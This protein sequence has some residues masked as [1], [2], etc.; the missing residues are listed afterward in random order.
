MQKKSEFANKKN[1]PIEKIIK[2][3]GIPIFIINLAIWNKN[4]R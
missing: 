2:L 3:V 4:P 1:H